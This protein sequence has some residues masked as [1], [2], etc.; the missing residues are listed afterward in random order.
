MEKDFDFK[1]M[2]NGG[3]YHYFTK[4]GKDGNWIYHRL[5]GPA[6]EPVDENCTY[7]KT[8]YFNGIQISAEE[9]KNSVRDREGLPYYKQPGF[10]ARF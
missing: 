7:K 5:D 2:K 10:K 1:K 6:I 8:Y 4:F 9:F 3:A